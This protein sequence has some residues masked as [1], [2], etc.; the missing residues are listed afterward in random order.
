MNYAHG[1]LSLLGLVG[2]SV[3]YFISEAR[4]HK[5][6]EQAI[7]VSYLAYVFWLGCHV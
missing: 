2:L 4:G 1:F 5:L 6:I 3:L 7:I